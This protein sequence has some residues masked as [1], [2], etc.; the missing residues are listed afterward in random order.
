MKREKKYDELVQRI[1][2]LDAAVR[3]HG[4]IDDKL[5]TTNRAIDKLIANWN[6]QYGQVGGSSDWKLTPQILS[7]NR[8]RDEPLQREEGRSIREP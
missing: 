4:S 5:L 8:R 1:V 2:N 7:Y 3:S 6:T